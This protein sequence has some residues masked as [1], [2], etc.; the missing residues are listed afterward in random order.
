MPPNFFEIMDFQVAAHRL[1]KTTTERTGQPFPRCAM[2][3]KQ[4]EQ[5]DYRPQ[6]KIQRKNY[7]ERNVPILCRNMYG[8]STVVVGSNPGQPWNTPSNLLTVED[9]ERRLQ[10]DSNRSADLFAL[11]TGRHT[12]NP[13]M[14]SHPPRFG[15]SLSEVSDLRRHPKILHLPPSLSEMMHTQVPI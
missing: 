7:W 13:S 1:Q 14:L 9:V 2:T 10:V 12:V 3:L 8:N 15:S 11:W 6:P 5:E 4:V